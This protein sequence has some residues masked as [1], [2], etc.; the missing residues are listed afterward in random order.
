MAYIYQVSFDIRP[1][2]MD[3]FR[4]SG[5]TMQEVRR[6]EIWVQEKNGELK[7]HP[8]KLGISDDEYTELLDSDLEPGTVIV[9]RIR[10]KKD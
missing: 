2:Q 10:E 4:Q 6:G 9:T 3:Q 5:D 1:D 7:R 8:V